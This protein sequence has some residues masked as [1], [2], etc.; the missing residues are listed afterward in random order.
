VLWCLSAAGDDAQMEQEIERIG[1]A[2]NE[3]LQAP[4]G[5]RCARGAAAVSRYWPSMPH[6]HLFLGGWN[7]LT[8]PLDALAG[9][10]VS[11]RM[12]A[13]L[14]KRILLHLTDLHFGPAKSKGHSW[15][16]EASELALPKHDRSGLLGSLIDDLRQQQI[17][18]DIVI[19]SGDLLDRGA[20]AGVPLARKFLIELADRLELP[21]S[22][23]V[24]IPG[25]HDVL[26]VPDPAERYKLF[27]AIRNDFYGAARPSFP[28]GTAPYNR[29]E[30]FGF[31]DKLELEVIAFNSCEALNPPKNEHGSVGQ[32]QRAAADALLTATE[33]KGLFRVA[34]MHHHL[35]LPTG[36][37]LRKDISVMEDAGTVRDWLVKRR[38]QL[39]L[40]GHQHLDW[41]ESREIKGWFLS[42]TAGASA[43]VGRYG[44]AEWELRLGYQV[45]MIDTPE[46][47]RRIRREYDPPSRAWIAAGREPTEKALRFGNWASVP[48]A[49]TPTAE[50]LATAGQT[51]TQSSVRRLLDEVFKVAA[52][53]DAFCHDHFPDVARDFTASLLRTEKATRLFGGATPSE[54]IEKLRKHHANAVKKHEGLIEYE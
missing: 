34:V 37:L 4:D 52:H 1:S 28:A 22:H 11:S 35:E 17:Q 19:V 50:K 23:V 27:D 53:F 36:Q 20:P 46:R 9:S 38:F 13:T 40:H 18:P 31:A 44:R 49:V 16:S 10:S 51:P 39:A 3:V 7:A 26:R 48:S 24:L 30:R 43:G 45:I 29:V 12:P 47:G 33:G 42:I 41:D 8:I 14:P 21:R 32:K 54:I 25:N 15:N 5:A 2:V 6:S